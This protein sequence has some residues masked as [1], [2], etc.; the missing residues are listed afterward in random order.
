MLSEGFVGAGVWRVP[1]DKRVGIVYN[2]LGER[3]RDYFNSL[4]QWNFFC[5]HEVCM[6]MAEVMRRWNVGLR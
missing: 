1:A 5:W 3:R 6:A 4:I 2:F